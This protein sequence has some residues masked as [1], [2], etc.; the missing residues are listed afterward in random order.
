M[1]Y[2]N[3]CRGKTTG[4]GR[5][6]PHDADADGLPGTPPVVNAVPSL[7]WNSTQ[8]K[9]NAY[10]KLMEAKRQGS[11]RLLYLR[12]PTLVLGSVLIVSGTIGF[13]THALLPDSV[14]AVVGCAAAVSVRALASASARDSEAAGREQAPT[15]GEERSGGG[16]GSAGGSVS[17]GAHVG[18]GVV[19]AP[20]GAGLL[21]RRRQSERESRA[22]RPPAAGAP[23]ARCGLPRT[24]SARRDVGRCVLIDRHG[25]EQV[26][27]SKWA[28]RG[29]RRGRGKRR[30]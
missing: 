22:R 3:A 16:V 25:G 29:V 30:R 11:L 8:A 23:P 10:E 5:R 6:E 24:A 1:I 15:G 7:D 13:L 18:V 12:G 9:V 28:G 14:A 27:D 4:D 20:R 19:G 26:G 21:C 17:V 2:G